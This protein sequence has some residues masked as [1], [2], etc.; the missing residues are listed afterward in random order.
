VSLEDLNLTYHEITESNVPELTD[1][2]TR[3][4]NDDAQKHLGKE[5][6]GPEGYDDGEFF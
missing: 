2:M 5:V 4:F 6:G 1:V 3:A